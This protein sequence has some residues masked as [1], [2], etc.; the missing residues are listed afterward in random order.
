M[1]E[2]NLEMTFEAV[3]LHNIVNTRPTRTSSVPMEVP[4]KSDLSTCSHSSKSRLILSLTA[5]YLKNGSEGGQEKWWCRER[6]RER[7]RPF[8]L[9]D[10]ETSWIGGYHTLNWTSSLCLAGRWKWTTGMCQLATKPATSPV[11]SCYQPPTISLPLSLF[12]SLFHLHPPG[13]VLPPFPFS[14]PS[15]SL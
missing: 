3:W 10:K 9:S 6:G 7:E 5:W 1:N 11:H 12:L 2:I 14:P 4:S 15:V 13:L 8:I